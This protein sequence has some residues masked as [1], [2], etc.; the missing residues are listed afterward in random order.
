MT[1]APEDL[2]CAAIDDAE[3]LR[4]PLDCLVACTEADPGAPFVP[5]ALEALVS[6]RREDR[7]R[8]EGLRAQLRSAGCRVTALDEALAEAAGEGSGRG[9]KQADV[10]I[11]LAHEAELFHSPDATAFADLVV[12]GH[13]ETW[14]V[15]TKGFRRW[16]ARRF[17]EA[18]GGAPNSEALQSAL[19][20]IE[21]KAHFDGPER[22]VHIRIGGLDGNLYLD[23][24]DEA[25]RAVEIGIEGWRIVEDPPVRFR[26]AAG[27]QALPTPE[28]GGSIEKL[29]NF[30][31][32]QGDGDFILVVAWV[33]AVLRDRGPYPVLVLSGE[34]GSAKSTFSSILRSL[35]DPNTAPLRALPR[36]DRDLFIA[37][38]NGH[39]LA[40]DNVS[41]LPTWISDTLC[42]LATGGGFA[43]R[44][45]YTYQD[46]VLFDAARPV[47][48]N[49]IEDI[50]TR[51]DL[52]DRAIFLM[53]EPIPE[54]RRRPE[55]EL[56]AAFNAIRPQLLGT[57]L[58]AVSHG[59]HRLPDTRLDS[60]PRM[61]DFAL[62]ATACETA[63]WSAGTFG[64][65]YA[66]NRDEAVDSV[67][68]AD[69]VGSAVRSLMNTRTEW[70]GTA[71][72]LLDALDEEVGEKVRKTKT[73]PSSA[74]AL[75]GRVRRAATFLR[76]VGIDITFEREGRAR[77]RTIWIS[78]KP[79]RA[80]AGPST[81]SA[82]SVL[83]PATRKNNGLDKGNPRTVTCTADANAGC[84]EPG[85]VRN[86]PKQN[87]EMVIADDA[88]AKSEG[89]SGG[90]RTRL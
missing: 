22:E 76:K 30:L 29:R 37:A 53:L 89:H 31:N 32:V 45:L 74:R 14:P 73:W 17:F 87:N 75:S 48:L 61:A 82:P 10:L 46:E 81:P 84:T 63:L 19:N 38:N 72:D 4:D 50:V 60:L 21:A 80:P 26:R 5:E 83:Q 1:S 47:I 86:N 9:P 58:D 90:W 64:A 23:L 16:L 3:E 13:R 69:P 71:S 28:P 49:G 55:K 78:R 66:G 25:W 6:L 36:E 70:T 57:L 88:D 15:R 8:F 33:L 54:D 35:L 77:T 18:T 51:P 52:A 2:I 20:V 59:L 27:M 85:A 43:V 7:A 24:G 67:I 41:G 79:E 39:V 42:R 44:Q 56:W 34:Q 11:D 68:E 62:W 65:A 12:N 40:F